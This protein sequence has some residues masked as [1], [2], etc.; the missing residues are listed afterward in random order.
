MPSLVAIGFTVAPRHMRKIKRLL[1][2]YI[3]YFSVLGSRIARTGRRRKTRNGS[4]DADLSK[5][6]PF[7]VSLSW[8]LLW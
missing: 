2:F 3:F 1:T 7:G 5:D 4:N 6:V 8:R